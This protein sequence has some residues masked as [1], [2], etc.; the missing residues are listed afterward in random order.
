MTTFTR[1]ALIAAALALAVVAVG[2]VPAQADS[3]GDTLAARERFFGAANVDPSGNVRDDRVI[4]SW[5]SVSSYAASFNGHV[6]L[7]DAWIARGSYSDYVPTTTEELI[8]LAPEYIFVGHGD[9]DHAAD[10]GEVASG[11][12]ATIV[13]SPEHCD[14]AKEQSGDDSIKC[15]EVVPAGAPPGI[16]KELDLL[17][18]VG[19]SVVSHIHSA[20]ESYENDRTPCPPVWN[21][22][23]TVNNPPSPE[24]IEHVTKW[25]TPRGVN[26][27]Y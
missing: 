17:P 12:G 22:Q 1:R 14:S 3:A 4:L 5:F 2:L 21:P 23:D 13:G 7:L 11:T 27:L 16:R 18:G 9:F 19:I 26:L 6:V 20:V 25:N 24:D 8:A 15:L 10:L